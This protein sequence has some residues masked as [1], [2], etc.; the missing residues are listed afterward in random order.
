AQVPYMFL[1]NSNFRFC[2]LGAGSSIIEKPLDHRQKPLL[3]SPE[4]RKL[5]GDSER[6][7]TK[8]MVPVINPTTPTT[9]APIVNPFPP[10]N[11]TFPPANPTFPPANPTVGPPTTGNP[12]TGSPTSSGGTWC[13]AS[14]SASQ[15][16]LQV[17][18]DY[19]CG[20][21]GADCSAIQ[22]TGSCYNP[23]TLR[24][25][26]SYAFNSYYQKNPAPTSCNFGGTASITNTDPSSGSCRFP[27]SS[28]SSPVSNPTLPPPTPTFD[29]NPPAPTFGTIPP[30][31]TFDG[32]MSPPGPTFDGSTPNAPPFDGSVPEPSGSTNSAASISLSLP[33]FTLTCLIPMLLLST[34]T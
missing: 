20:F 6:Y 30:G 31:P 9:T 25:H 13:A 21:G 8:Q 2:L 5:T 3:S 29:T 11:P 10:A 16:A 34:K 1:S 7:V 28:R 18:L 23:N 19:A 32:S 15:T 27:S 12:T 17:A 22:P 24:D 26:A 33:I 14:P 4:G